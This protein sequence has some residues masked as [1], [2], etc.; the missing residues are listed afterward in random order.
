MAAGA[1]ERSLMRCNY[2]RVGPA[3]FSEIPAGN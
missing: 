1:K 3:D 2:D